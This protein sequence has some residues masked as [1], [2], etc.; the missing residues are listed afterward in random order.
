V[1]AEVIWWIK[2]RT[3]AASGGMEVGIKWDGAREN[4]PECW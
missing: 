1:L 2:N 4:F 3:V